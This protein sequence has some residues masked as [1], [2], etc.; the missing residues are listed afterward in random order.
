MIIRNR[1]LLGV[2][3]RANLA[4]GGQDCS[5][6]LRIGDITFLAEGI[7]R[8]DTFREWLAER[9]CVFEQTKRSGKKAHGF[10]DVIVKLGDRKTE[11][12]V[13][14]ASQDLD[15]RE[16]RRVVDELGLNWDDLPGP[17]SRA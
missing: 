9:G 4:E 17:Q 8:S 1:P 13:K 15:P 11:L 10:P 2:S 14:G 3:K 7:M 12:H 16:V 6:G 5:F